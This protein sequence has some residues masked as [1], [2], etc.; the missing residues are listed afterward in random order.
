MKK[1]LHK[2]LLK[3]A[4]I[5]AMAL[6]HLLPGQLKAQ[7]SKVSGT[8][9]GKSN[10]VL[11]GATVTV[12][13]TTT[14]TATDASGKFSIEAAPGRTLVITSIG[15]ETREVKVGNQKNIAISLAATSS[16][17]EDLV[18]VAYGSVRKKDLTGSVSVVNVEN[19]KKTAS[20][21]VAKI[22]QG[23]A[24]GVTVQFI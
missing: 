18:V 20:Y 22:L 23:Q 4:C 5:L 9:T 14:A 2:A 15:Y 6:L 3:A 1:Q 24:A 21:D 19:A 12:K 17:M 16:T 10:E 8:V 11:V 7:S 13:Q